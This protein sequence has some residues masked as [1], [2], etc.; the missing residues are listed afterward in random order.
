[1]TSQIDSAATRE[2]LLRAAHELEAALPDV[3]TDSRAFAAIAAAIA[4]TQVVLDRDFLSI[5]ATN[6]LPRGALDQL[7]K[8]TEKP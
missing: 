6:A 1:V 2:K 5:R 7:P 8:S 3:Q 4:F